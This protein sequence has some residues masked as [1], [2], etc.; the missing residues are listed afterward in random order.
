[1]SGE[2]LLHLSSPL[3]AEGDGD[4]VLACGSPDGSP[5]RNLGQLLWNP[6]Q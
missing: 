4:G 6:E 5:K 1:M 3:R 2:V